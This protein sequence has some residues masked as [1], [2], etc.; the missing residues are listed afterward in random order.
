MSCFQLMSNSI[1]GQLL[2]NPRKD[3]NLELVRTAKRFI[4]LLAKPTTTGFTIFGKDLVAVDRKPAVIRM[5]NLPAAGVAVL[6]LSKKLMMELYWRLKEQLGKRMVLCFTDTDS[7]AVRIE[8]PDLVADLRPLM[9]ILDTSSLPKNHALY[10]GRF[11]RCQGR[12][13]I[14]YGAHKVLRFA[15]VRAKCYALDLADAEGNRSAIYKAKGV[16]KGALRRS[17]N[18]EDYKRCIFD[19]VAKYV[20][21]NSIQTDRRHNLY[22]LEQR[23]VAL[24]N[25]DNKRRILNTGRTMAF[26]YN[27]PEVNV[28]K[29]KRKKKKKFCV[30]M[31]QALTPVVAPVL[32]DELD[33]EDEDLL[34]VMMGLAE[35]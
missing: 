13:K 16:N 29:K 24:Q 31:W 7:L 19:G 5:R 9:D 25:F 11:A 32:Q 22:T 6:D 17:V 2:R 33:S 18:F 14:E 20:Q 34:D 3:R 35:E 28:K 4:K 8:T 21:F 10:D 26:G 1:Y 27:P 12:L 23:K 15:G 30:C